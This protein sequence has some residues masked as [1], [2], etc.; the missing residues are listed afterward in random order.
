MAC[1]HKN[2]AAKVAVARLTDNDGSKVVGFN[3]EVAISCAEC[4]QPFQFMG[5]PAGYLACGASMSI[6][7]LRAHLAIC[8]QGE[9]AAPLDIIGQL[10]AGKPN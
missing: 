10:L 6:D 7:G 3:A 9:M 2:F 4:G 5:L 1:E 8:P